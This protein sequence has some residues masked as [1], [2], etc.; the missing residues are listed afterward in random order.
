MRDAVDV[1]IV[2]CGAA[3]SVLA[4][5]LAERKLS[6]VVL[7]AGPWVRREDIPT[8]RFDWELHLFDFHPSDERR[9][10]ITLAPGSNRFSIARFKGVG[11]ST[12]RWEGFSTRMHPGDLRRQTICGVGADW[13]L[14]YADLEPHYDRVETILGVAGTRDSKFDPPRGPYPNPPL[15]FSCAVQQVKAGCDELGLHT[16]H[17]PMAILTRPTETRLPCNYC[18]G[19]WWGCFMGALSNMGQTYVPLARTAGAEI[20]ARCTVAR[21]VMEQSGKRARGVEYFDE[22]GK[23][24]MQSARAIA[25]CGNGVET[26]RLL[27]LSATA[28][29]PD[30]LANSSGVL[31]RYFSG[32]TLVEAHGLL[33]Q[34]V[35]GYRGPNIGGMVQDFYDHDD[36]RSFLGGYLIALRNGEG[37]PLQFHQ[38]WMRR[39][40]LFGEA[41]IRGMNETF[42]HSLNISAYGE[43]LPQEGNQVSLDKEATDIFGLPVPRIR[44]V[45]GGNEKRMQAH[46]GWTLHS[47]L[48]AAGADQIGVE[49]YDSIM[50]THLL[51]TCRMGTDPKTSVTDPF[52]HTH[53]VTNLFIADGS[54]FPCGTPANPTLTILALAT[55]VAL[56]M[57]GRFERG[58]L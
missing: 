49:V 2:G 54:L 27:L 33:E 41:L 22:S 30:G 37:G 58:E 8:P 34:R 50:G 14:E 6:V 13:P 48:D 46:M 32:H 18:G 24:D 10:R 28:D 35:D 53:D 47:I 12:M 31:G 26:P 1:C 43:T 17:A 19:C 38:R 55:R 56:G 3:G 5:E 11:G 20:R 25:V 57:V 4:R 45:L 42:G 23:L 40:G 16:A 21:I 29:H 44:T 9:D 15:E 7:D 52:G 39:K 36:N 51:G